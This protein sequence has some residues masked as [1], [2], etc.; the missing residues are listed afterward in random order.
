MAG[1]AIKMGT[2]FTV[3]P[4]NEIRA[5]KVRIHKTGQVVL[6]NDEVKP[7]WE[8]DCWDLDHIIWELAEKYG[9]ERSISDWVVDSEERLEF[10][11]QGGV[12]CG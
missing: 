9:V 2:C 3:V 4:R 11:M 10:L 8:N 6:Y 12:Q 7:L 5:R 1:I